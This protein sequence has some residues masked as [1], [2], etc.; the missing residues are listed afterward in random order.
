MFLRSSFLF[1]SFFALACG[2]RATS[3]I[4]E[5]SSAGEGGTAGVAGVAG[6]SVGGGGGAPIAD[7]SPPPLAPRALEISCGWGYACARLEDLTIS[8]WGDPEIQ[9]PEGKFAH[10]AKTG[11]DSGAMTALTISGEAVSFGDFSRCPEGMDCTY[12]PPGPHAYVESNSGSSIYIRYFLDKQGEL[13]SSCDHLV[14]AGSAPKACQRAIEKRPAGP[15]TAVAHDGSYVYGIRK[16]GELVCWNDDTGDVFTSCMGQEGLRFKAIGYNLATMCGITL[17]GALLCT[18][19]G[20]LLQGDFVDFFSMNTRSCGILADGG[21][22]CLNNQVTQ[23]V[24]DAWI[25]SAYSYKQGCGGFGQYVC[26]LTTEGKVLCSGQSGSKL[27]R[28]AIRNVP[29]E[30]AAAPI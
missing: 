5:G 9:A 21:V 27:D 12:N 10:L 22:R 6:A 25:P 28:T 15:F 3:G 23:T 13:S 24:I 8:C 30:F 26:L 1:I 2:G 19:I 11:R 18:G 29:S 7:A 4:G 16:D 17:D 20:D 14:Q